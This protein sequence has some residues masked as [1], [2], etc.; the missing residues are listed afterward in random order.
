MSTHLLR[1]YVDETGDR[2]MKPSS[3]EYFAFAAVLCRDANT[4]VLGEALADLVREAGKPPGSVLHWSKN[5]KDHAL[6]TYAAQILSGLPIRLLFVVVP[7]R[8]IQ[9]NTHLARSTVGYYNFAA[10]LVLERV[11]Y[12]TASRQR[13]EQKTDPAAICRTKVTFARVKGFRPRLLQD[14]VGLLRTRQGNEAWS[15]GLTTKVAVAGQAESPL[16]QWADIAAGA[17][18]AAVKLDRYGNH[19]PAYLMRLG[20]LIDCSG[21]GRILGYGIKSLGGEDYLQAMPWWTADWWKG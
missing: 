21:D 5:M 6:R 2:G 1:A 11:G 15:N 10:R 13:I 14:Y 3:S 8:A 20:R 18:D 7:K 17:F 12:F 16:L 19:E 9:P 4:T